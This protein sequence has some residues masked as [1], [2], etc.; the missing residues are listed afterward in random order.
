MKAAASLAELET[1]DMIVFTVALPSEHARELSVSVLGRT[2]TLTGP[3]GYEH[4]VEFPLEADLE[5]L[6]ARLYRGIVELR[7]PREA[8]PS[9]RPIPLQAL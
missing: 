8:L 7:A 5:R 3:A 1:G 9:A 6:Q 4:E 2:V